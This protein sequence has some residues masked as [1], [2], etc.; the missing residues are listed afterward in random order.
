LNEPGHAWIVLILTLALHV[1]DEALNDFLSFYIPLAQQIR[2]AIPFLPL[3][4]FSTQVWLFGLL[5]AVVILLLLSPLVFSRNRWIRPFAW[6]FAVVMV[7][8]GLLHFLS[9]A[10]FR[11]V[12]AGTWS[13]LPLIAAAVWLI[14]CLRRYWG[15]ASPTDS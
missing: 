1:I 14:V 10:V 3:P 6:F 9:S 5:G 15:V 11:R 13:S 4:I 12:I 7:F 8:N 2:E